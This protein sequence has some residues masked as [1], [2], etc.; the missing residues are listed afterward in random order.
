VTSPKWYADGLRFECTQ[1]GNC[2]RNHG[3]YSYVYLTEVELR[4]IPPHLGLTRKEFL[5]RYCTKEPHSW[6]TLR[7]DQ[8]ACPFLSAEG[9]CE[10]YPVRPEQCRTWPFWKE[11][12]EEG[13]WKGPVKD[14]CPGLD[15]GPLH[16]ASVVERMAR[17]TEDWFDAPERLGGRRPSEPPEGQR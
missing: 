17:E 2:C 12:L 4:E 14:C 3:D 8:P 1:C 10:I 16:P 13:V 6:W 9:R 15:Q 5:E 7:M 11:N